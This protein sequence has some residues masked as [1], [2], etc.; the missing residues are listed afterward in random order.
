MGDFSS[1]HVM[2]NLQVEVGSGSKATI[3]KVASKYKPVVT[4]LVNGAA[5]TF[6]KKALSLPKLRHTITEEVKCL[7]KSAKFYAPPFLRSAPFCVIPD[8]LI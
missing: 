8:Q 1:I 7:M 4:A 3:Q 6:A 5:N 2:Y